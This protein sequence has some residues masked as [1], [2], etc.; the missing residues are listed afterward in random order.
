LGNR[1]NCI[2]R[3]PH[4][5]RRPRFLRY[6][7]VGRSSPP[8][9]VVQEFAEFSSMHVRGWFV[10]PD[11][12]PSPDSP[13]Q[14]ECQREWVLA[15]M[16]RTS[17]LPTSN[18]FIA[19]DNK[20][21]QVGGTEPETMRPWEVTWG[22]QHGLTSSVSFTVT[23]GCSY[24]P[25]P[26]PSPRK[27]RFIPNIDGWCLLCKCELGVIGAPRKVCEAH[28]QFDWATPT[29]DTFGRIPP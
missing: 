10:N 17:I 26:W 24:C 23:Q 6:I 22:T 11:S 14:N 27:S 7:V 28:G 16:K 2:K 18:E 5:V 4:S 9:F 15:R 29:H 1:L 12:L 3:R 13:T 20:Y 21:Y 25:P 19:A 8:Y